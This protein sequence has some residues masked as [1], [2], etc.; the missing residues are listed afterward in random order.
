MASLKYLPNKDKK[1]TVFVWG[2]RD[3]GASFLNVPDSLHTI[4]HRLHREGYHIEPY[5]HDYY[6]ERS[7]RILNPFYREYEL[8][9]LLDDDLAELLP[10]LH[11]QLDSHLFF[12]GWSHFAVNYRMNFWKT[13]KMH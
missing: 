13:C 4:A 9:A 10:M 12:I 1:L 2:D 11:Y 6:S 7:E 3:M 8:Q 5:E